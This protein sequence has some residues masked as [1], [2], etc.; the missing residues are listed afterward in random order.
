METFEQHYDALCA[1]IKKHM[2]GLV[3]NYPRA[4]DRLDKK[5]M[6]P[7]VEKFMAD[8]RKAKENADCRKGSAGK[9]EFLKEFDKQWH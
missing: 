3:H 9:G 6:A 8:L 7:Y 2:P 1:A 4:D 5:T